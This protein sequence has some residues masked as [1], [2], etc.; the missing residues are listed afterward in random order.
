MRWILDS[1]QSSYDGGSIDSSIVGVS[2]KV[3]F[4]KLNETYIKY[5]GTQYI[6]LSIYMYVF[7]TYPTG[8]RRS[9]QHNRAQLHGL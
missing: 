9:G 3:L 6:L 7:I 4:L 2:Y 5:I 1:W 8:L